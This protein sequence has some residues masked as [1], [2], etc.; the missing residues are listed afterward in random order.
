MTAETDRI[1]PEVV[2][3]IVAALTDTD[4]SRLPEDATR[5]EKDAAQDRYFTATVAGREQRDRQTR[6]WELLLRKSYDDPPTWTQL[7]DDLPEGSQDELGD[8]FDALPEGAQ[9]EYTRRYGSPAGV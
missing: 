1:R 3:A 5:A 9:A 4:P 6:A 8:L 7:F 2:D